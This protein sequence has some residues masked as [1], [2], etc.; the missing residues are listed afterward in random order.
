MKKLE[1]PHVK[2][3]LCSEK[4]AD[5]ETLE[6]HQRSE[7]DR[8][9]ASNKF[10]SMPKLPK[11][12]SA[13]ALW[14]IGWVR[15][16]PGK[17]WTKPPMPKMRAHRISEDAYHCLFCQKHFACA[18]GFKSHFVLTFTTKERCLDQ[19]ELGAL[20]FERNASGVYRIT[21]ITQYLPSQIS[22]LPTVRQ[23]IAALE[24][25]EQATRE[26]QNAAEDPINLRLD[27]TDKATES[28]KP[29]VKATLPPPSVA[30][31]MFTSLAADLIAAASDAT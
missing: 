7:Q 30:K 18:T 3:T 6:A 13:E 17:I 21:P 29:V 20:A 12:L 8:H 2:C 31:A 23:E 22:R 26:L 9:C 28:D 19:D 4:F 15:N 14:V 5:E 11:C 16:R 25:Y 1:P 24:A 10:L 27:P